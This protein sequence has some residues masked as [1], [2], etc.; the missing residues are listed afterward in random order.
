MS[1]LLILP[2]AVTELC[3]FLPSAPVLRSR[4]EVAS[5]VISGRF[6]RLPVLDKLVEFRGPRLNGSPE[7]GLETVRC[8][9]FDRF[10]NFRKC[11]LEAVGDVIS[12][13]DVE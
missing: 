4:P 2:Q 7:I 6:V 3:A 8:D 9:I 11:R 10:S 5:D 13:T 1:L 12:F